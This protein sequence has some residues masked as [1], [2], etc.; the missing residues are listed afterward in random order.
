MEQ[1]AVRAEVGIGTLTG[2]SR[3]RLTCTPPWS[4]RR[5]VKHDPKLPR[6]MAEDG[7][8]AMV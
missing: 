3:T 7:S 4:T 1:I 5:R 2:A 8:T 6:T